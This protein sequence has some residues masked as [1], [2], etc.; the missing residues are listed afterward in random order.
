MLYP[1]MKQIT[2]RHRP[3][4]DLRWI[5][6]SKH[7]LISGSKYQQERKNK[8]PQYLKCDCCSVQFG[9]LVP[10]HLKP[11]SFSCGWFGSQKRPGSVA[12]DCPNVNWIRHSCPQHWR[13]PSRKVVKVY[14][15]R[16]RR[17]MVWWFKFRGGRGPVLVDLPWTPR[18]GLGQFLVLHITSISPSLVR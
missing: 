13:L 6:S 10:S 3:F 8:H 11:T 7:A 14:S 1:K 17:N 9:I 2:F 12:R 15:I 18:L 5:S 16:S 4:G